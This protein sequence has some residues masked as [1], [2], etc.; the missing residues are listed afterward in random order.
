MGPSSWWE[1]VFTDEE[2]AI[3]HTYRRTRTE[4]FPWDAC[5]LL[6]V[7]VTEA[8]LGPRL[9]TIEASR[10]R[11]TACG[12]PGWVALDKIANLLSAFR[13][14]GQPVT[15][16]KPDWA[17]EEYI[18]GTT[19][20]EPRRVTVDPIP[21]AIAPTSRELVIEKPKASAFF[22]TALLTYLIRR[23]VRGLVVAG[24][25]TSGCVRMSIVDAASHGLDVVLAVDACFDR[26]QLS[27]A[28]A[29]MELDTKYARA[30]DSSHIAQRLAEV[31][32][33]R[34]TASKSLAT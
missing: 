21:T 20:G 7:D 18:G 24:C 26:S 17:A 29:I 28:V 30:L 9:P 34:T 10:Q 3:Y 4:A 1:D 23:R 27:H 5:A 22:G 16:V 19:S 32:R 8:F 33:S 13:E 2:C 31:A 25:S 6:V 15:F 12:L 11:R 14:A